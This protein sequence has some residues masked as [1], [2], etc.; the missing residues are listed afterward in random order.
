MSK[1]K[2]Q[3]DLDELI[4]DSPKENYQSNTTDKVI[5][6]INSVSD[7][8][9]ETHKNKISSQSHDN[10]FKLIKLLD[11]KVDKLNNKLNKL[12]A[13]EDHNP[14]TSILLDKISKRLDRKSNKDDLKILDDQVKNLEKSMDKSNDKLNKFQNMT[15]PEKIDMNKIEK[16]LTDEIAKRFTELQLIMDAR[17]DLINDKVNNIQK[18]LFSQMTR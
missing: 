18:S 17:L 1:N 10:Y 8:L 14:A 4:D 7:E 3:N 5:N 15:V 13:D 9:M 11:E 2:Y 6:V 16:N 12:Y